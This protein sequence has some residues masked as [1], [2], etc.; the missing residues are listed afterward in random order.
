VEIQV[1]RPATGI[2]VKVGKLTLKTTE[3]KTIYDL[4][5]KMIDCLMKEKV[6]IFIYNLNGLHPV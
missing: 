1:D 2:G 4:G 6:S 3:M 5:N